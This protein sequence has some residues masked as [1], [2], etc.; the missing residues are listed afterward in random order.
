MPT[1]PYKV[2]GKRVPST[3]TILSRFKD[4]TGLIIWANNL[5]LEGKNYFDELAKAGDIGTNFHDLAELYIKGE[6][7]PVADDPV[8]HKVFLIF[9]EWWDNYECEIVFTE[10]N[11]EN[12][13]LLIG[14]CPDLL[15]KK[16]NRYI[17]IDFKTSKSIYPDHLIQLSAY[18]QLIKEG[19]D[20]TIDEA[21]IYR[22]PKDPAEDQ[23][24][25]KKFTPDDLKV[26]LKQF[27][28]FRQAFDIDKQIKKIT[29]RKND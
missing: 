3:T 19:D 28:I 8:V 23:P 29:R 26:G 21:I 4:A 15:V 13:N 27:K 25:I 22:F 20:I 6:E 9:K 16:N 12:E 14:G 2:N 17:L 10:K 7:P 24:E 5:G 18:S 1:T 11:Y